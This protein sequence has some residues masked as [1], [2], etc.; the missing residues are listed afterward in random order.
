MVKNNSIE[1]VGSVEE[2]ELALAEAG[3]T[4]VEVYRGIL[5]GL[6]AVKKVEKVVDGEIVMVEEPDET[7]RIKNRELA[8][9]AFGDLKDMD[10]GLTVQNF[11]FAS[12]VKLAY[13][14]VTQA[15]PTD[16]RIQAVADNGRLT[17]TDGVVDAGQ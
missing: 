2:R 12:M 14:Q 9:K 13:T 1:K 17:V 15:I 10:K 11:T 7:V 5:E 8:L 6:R 16:D 3:L 4:R